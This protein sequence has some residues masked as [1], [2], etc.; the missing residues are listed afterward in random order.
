MRK[1]ES[2]NELLIGVIP[3][4]EE[5]NQLKRFVVFQPEFVLLDDDEVELSRL[6]NNADDYPTNIN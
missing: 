6:V 5:T 1:Y 3:Y 4:R 2:F